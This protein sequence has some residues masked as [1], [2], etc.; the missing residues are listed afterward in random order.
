MKSRALG[1][2]EEDERPFRET[3]VASSEPPRKGKVPTQVRLGGHTDSDLLLKSVR[4]AATRS[5]LRRRG[6][7]EV[8]YACSRG[9]FVSWSLSTLGDVGSREV[10]YACSL[11]SFV[12]E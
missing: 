11:G 3:Y 10:P 1:E 7:R 5:T 4:P 2:A 8:P 9:F 6:S 12:T